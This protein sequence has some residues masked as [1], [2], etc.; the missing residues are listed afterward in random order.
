MA[1]GDRSAKTASKRFARVGVL[2][3]AV[4]TLACG[5]S[6]TA[7]T[8]AVPPEASPPAASVVLISGSVVD[9]ASRH[10]ADVK[11]EM[12]DGPQA[13][14]STM[15]DAAGQFSFSGSFPRS[16]TFRATKVGYADLMETRIIAP[17]PP[18]G[19][20]TSVGL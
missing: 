15:T 14:A 6:S 19:T 5:G 16:I 10:L 20:T 3:V 8:P 18:P 11:V 1:T 4:G 12:V 9:T 7:P 2:G 17:G 13:G